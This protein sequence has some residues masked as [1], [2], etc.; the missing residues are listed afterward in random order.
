M[1]TGGSGRGA[2]SQR[3]QKRDSLAIALRPKLR[4]LS[5]LLAAH[6]P[7]AMLVFCA[8]Q[9][10]AEEVLV[11]LASKRIRCAGL[12]AS[13][14]NRDRAAALR[15]MRDGRALVL[16][17]TEHASRGLDL[18]RLSHVVNFD[19]PRTATSYVHRAGRVGRIGSPEGLVVSF[20]EGD[21][22]QSKA[23]GSE[24][25]RS[26]DLPDGHEAGQKQQDWESGAAGGSHALA[27]GEGE[28]NDGLASNGDV[29][30]G[31]APGGPLEATTSL[32]VPQQGVELMEVVRAVGAR[33]GGLRW[34]YLQ[35]G[36]LLFGD[37]GVMLP[38][39]ALGV[40]V[41]QAGDLQDGAGESGS[42]SGDDA[43]VDE[44][45]VEE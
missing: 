18:P 21:A 32:A 13:M 28:A 39:D 38:A 25:W 10:T 26:G 44:D 34:A 24:L 40:V 7:A 6:P 8:T 20:V 22:V 35:N 16:V 14:K 33:G 4:A 45:E 19:P 42:E 29:P 37:A 2:A 23:E 11:Y 12:L 43:D 36:E 41:G 5:R 15:R 30:R 17:A 3:G 1:E 31:D 27:S 9:E